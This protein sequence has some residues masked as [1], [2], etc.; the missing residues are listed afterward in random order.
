[1]YDG[2]D[3]LILHHKM[4]DGTDTLIL[5]HINVWWYWHYDIT[6]YKCM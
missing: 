2:T 1:M 5:H 6:S 4:Y 3:T